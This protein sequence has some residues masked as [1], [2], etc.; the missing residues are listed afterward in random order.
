VLLAQSACTSQL[1]MSA[2]R[3]HEWSLPPQSTS[4]SLPS[5][6]PFKHADSV[7]A[8]DG[9]AVGATVGTGVGV[10]V[11]GEHNIN[12]VLQLPF[13]QSLSARHAFCA[14]HL[15]HAVLPPQ[16]TSVSLPS[17]TP[18]KHGTGEG[19]CVGV[20][21]GMSVGAAVGAAVG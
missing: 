5:F 6:T 12:W 3:L 4:V 10:A 15:A 1:F 2:H 11:G 14:A 17:F 9:E 7:G 18:F 8:M 21:V 20:A 19:A 16:S 13:V